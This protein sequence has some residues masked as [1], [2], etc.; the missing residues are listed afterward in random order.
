MENDE[1]LNLFELETDPPIGVQLRLPWG[2]NESSFVFVPLEP[3]NDDQFELKL[4]LDLELSLKV[5]DYG[6][7][8]PSE[9]GLAFPAPAPIDFGEVD[10][11]ELERT[12]G[13]VEG[14]ELY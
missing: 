5:R 10:P 7:S 4:Q 13:S 12:D 11:S 8:D 6:E 14:P 9:L 1:P 2:F 3:K